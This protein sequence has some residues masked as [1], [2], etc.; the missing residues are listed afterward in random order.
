VTPLLLTAF[1]EA[2]DRSLPD[3]VFTDAHRWRYALPDPP[4]D[5]PCLFDSG[6]RLGAG[7]DWCG[8]PKIEGAFLSGGALAERVLQRTGGGV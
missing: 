3:P 6:A 8:G 7:G 5:A 2:L 4:L 1:A